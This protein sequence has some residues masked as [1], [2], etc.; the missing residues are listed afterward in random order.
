MIKLGFIGCGRMASYHAEVLKNLDA[1][2]VSACGRENSE[3]AKEFAQK[4]NA[5][6]VYRSWNELI[7]NSKAD[8]LDALW[9]TTS[10]HSTEELLIPLLKTNLPLFVEKPVALNSAKIEE[11]IEVQKQTRNKVAVGMNRRFYDFIPELKEYIKNY[12]L[13]SVEIALPEQLNDKNLKEEEQDTVWFT[14]SIHEL[15]LIYHLLGP[16]DVLYSH[17]YKTNT[18]QSYNCLFESKKIPIQLNACWNSPW[19]KTIRFFFDDHVIELS[20]I[21]TMKI[22]QGIKKFPATK[23]KPINQ[24]KPNLI[25][26]IETSTKY[27]PGIY[28]QDK[29]VIDSIKNNFDNK[30]ATLKDAYETTSLIEKILNK[31]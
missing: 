7:Q 25:K 30:L 22:Y 16:I 19:N 24:F 11:A 6:E 5:P 26:E 28:E 12:E 14:N 20:P 21:E 9:I 3:R 31:K 8:A 1:K 29:S 23:N 13:K 27:K 10:H 4:Y 2:I 17:K 15:D 18:A